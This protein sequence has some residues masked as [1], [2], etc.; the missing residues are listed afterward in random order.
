MDYR[1]PVADILFSLRHVAGFDKAAADGVFGELD[2]ETASAVIE[3]AGRFA[4]Q[5]IA[6]L[7]R[8]GDLEGARW[9]NGVVRMLAGF[10][11]VFRDWAQAGWG[12]V[13]GAAEFGGMGL[14][15]TIGAACTEL[16][17]GASMSFSL[18]PLLNEGA[19]NA[20]S[21]YGG[22]ELRR[23]YLGKLIK[24]EWTGTMNLT[25]PQAGSDLGAV[26]TRAGQAGSGFDASR[27]AS[28]DG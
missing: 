21:A 20:L 3:E 12:G 10:A 14:P 7:N 27:W 8:I 15:H 6:P 11:A 5:A 22:E 4:T 19:I 24:G 18:C 23:L 25:E 17:A 26:K 16:W 13:T 2:G 9:D 1:S 28:T